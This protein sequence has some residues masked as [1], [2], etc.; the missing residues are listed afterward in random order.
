LGASFLDDSCVIDLAGAR[1]HCQQ[2]APNTRFVEGVYDW[3]HVPAK[4]GGMIDLRRVGTVEDD[5]TD[6]L[7]LDNLRGAWY[8]VTNTR[9]Q[10]GFGMAWEQKVFPALWFWQVY[11]GAYAPPWYGRTFNIALEPFSTRQR[12]LSA[13]IQDNSAHV[14]AAGQSIETQ[15]LALAYAGISGVQEISLDGAVV[16]RAN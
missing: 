15:F 8:A 9:R 4:H 6:A 10:V 3:P 5:T 1:V 14:L 2:L 7:F 12:T 16:A 11:G 13:A